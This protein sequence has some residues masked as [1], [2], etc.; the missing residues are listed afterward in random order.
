MNRLT[1]VCGMKWNWPASFT[2]WSTIRLAPVWY[3]IQPIGLGRVRGWQAKAPAPRLRQ[4][5]AKCRNS[6]ARTSACATSS[7]P[8]ACEK[9]DL[10][11]RRIVPIS[12]L[13]MT[14]CR[15]KRWSLI[16]LGGIAGAAVLA[17]V[18]FYGLIDGALRSRLPGYVAS[19]LALALA[20]AVL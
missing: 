10:Q 9:C 13:A 6:M 14:L 1:I 3:R 11:L 7:P 19:V 17:A 4:T 2:M 8:K 20:L 15:L 18:P 5:L 12:L 16:V